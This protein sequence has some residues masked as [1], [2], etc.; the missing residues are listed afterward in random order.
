MFNALATP[1]TYHNT[2]PN[3]SLRASSTSDFKTPAS[4][5]I[6]FLTL[7]AISPA[8]PAKPNVV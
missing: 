8:S 3:S 6:I 7:L 1:A 4:S 5:L 2:S